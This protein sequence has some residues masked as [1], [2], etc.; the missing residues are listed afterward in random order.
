M[1]QYDQGRCT[2]EMLRSPGMPFSVSVIPIM[3]NA[4]VYLLE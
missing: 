4:D 1:S 2:E 3:F